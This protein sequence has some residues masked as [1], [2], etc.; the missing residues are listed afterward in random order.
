MLRYAGRKE[1]KIEEKYMISYWQKMGN[2]YK[3]GSLEELG[4][5]KTAYGISMMGLCTAGV[6]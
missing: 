4:Y 6:V 5:V 1:K 3:S 2:L